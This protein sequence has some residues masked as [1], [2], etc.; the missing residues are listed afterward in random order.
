MV[1]SWGYRKPLKFQILLKS[2]SGHQNYAY[3]K[4]VT[5][6]TTLYHAAC[7]NGTDKILNFSLENNCF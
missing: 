4:Q 7:T 3:Q 6:Q 5:S 1:F 2:S